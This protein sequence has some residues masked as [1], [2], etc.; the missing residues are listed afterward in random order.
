MVYDTPR[1][2][3]LSA[4]RQVNSETWR[5]LFENIR[6]EMAGLGGRNSPPQ[7]PPPATPSLG[8]TEFLAE[9]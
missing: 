7:P 6:T 8:Q 1:S 3:Y 2:L 4:G 5:C 9:L